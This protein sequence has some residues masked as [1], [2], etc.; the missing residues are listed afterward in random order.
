MKRLA[1]NAAEPGRD[2][3]FLHGIVERFGRHDRHLQGLLRTPE[4]EAAE[5]FHCGRFYIVPPAQRPAV[6][7]HEGN[8]AAAFHREPRSNRRIDTGGEEC[9]RFSL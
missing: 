3:L 8:F 1:E 7:V 5:V 2:L 4:R 6:N 9:E